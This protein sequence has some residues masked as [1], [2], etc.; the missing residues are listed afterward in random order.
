MVTSKNKLIFFYWFSVDI[1]KVND[2]NSRI[3]DPDQNLD[4]NPDP[5]PLIRGMD[6]RIRIRIHTKMSWNRSTEVPY[7]F[8]GPDWCVLLRSRWSCRCR[9]SR[10]RAEARSPV[11]S[12]HNRGLQRDVVY[13]SW[14]IAPLVYE[15]KCGGGVAGS[16]PMRTAV[17][18]T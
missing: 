7:I 13:L 2:K 11:G 9:Y 4:T 3:Q 10:S 1:L 16:Q 18:I 14:P 8:S 12:L 5:D 17:H 6:S 15:A